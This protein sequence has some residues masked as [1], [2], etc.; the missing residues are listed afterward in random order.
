MTRDEQREVLEAPRRV[1]GQEEHR[2]RVLALD[3]YPQLS[4][5]AEAQ[6]YRLTMTGHSAGVQY[7]AFSPDGRTVLS[8]SN[9]RTLK[10]D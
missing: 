2:L 8:A 7:C 1:L 3:R 5:G 10:H 9:D 6:A 4:R